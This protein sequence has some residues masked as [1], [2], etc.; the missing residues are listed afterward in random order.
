MATVSWVSGRRS[1]LACTAVA[2]VLY[3]AGAVAQER[4]LG[5][6]RLPA[7]FGDQPC[8]PFRPDD[9]RLYAMP[10]GRSQVGSVRVENPWS[11]KSANGCDGL[12]V[13][14]FRRGALEPL[15]LPVRE[16]AY[17]QP[18]AIVLERRDRWARIRLADGDAWVREPARSDFLPL[19]TLLSDRLTYLTEEW[20]G[21]LAAVP[22]GPLR[23]GAR[24]ELG[25]QAARVTA[26]RV[27]NGALWTQVA[28]LARGVCDGG[29]TPPVVAQGWVPAH[30]GSGEPN[31]WFY[32]RGC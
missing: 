23:G 13:R 11:T 24:V 10:D 26:F 29:E 8:E 4:V 12:R 27:H 25:E 1:A 9:V 18:A 31:V 19:Q 3:G 17:E 2:C 30:A 22:G 5:L 15:P 14:V 16:F 28:V 20:D 7:V 32:S 6:L 21:R